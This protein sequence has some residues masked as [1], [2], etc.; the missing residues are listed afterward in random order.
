VASQ[1]LFGRVVAKS[2]LVMAGVVALSFGL[3]GVASAAAIT[4]TSIS[5]TPSIPDVLTAN[6]TGGPATSYQW[7]DCTGSV[8]ATVVGAGSWTPQAGCSAIGAATASTYALQSTDYGF[9]VTVAASESG[10]PTTGVAASV[11]VTEPAPAATGSPSFA[12]SSADVFAGTTATVSGTGFVSP[13]YNL[14]STTYQ[15]YDCTAQV[16]ADSVGVAAPGGCAAIGG[17]T[18]SSYQFAVNDVGKFVAFSETQTNGAGFATVFSTST[19]SAIVGATPVNTVSPTIGSQTAFTVTVTSHGTWTGH[20]APSSYTVTWYRC[21]ATEV[22]GST[23]P[24]ACTAIAGSATTTPTGLVTYT[25]VAADQNQYVLAGVSANNGIASANTAY[26]A[27]SAQISGVAPAVATPPA[28]TGT[29]QVGQTLSVSSG[30]WTGLPQPLNFNYQWYACVTDPAFSGGGNATGA[31]PAGLTGH[32]CASI[33]GATANTFI[34][35][36]TQATQFMV[37]EVSTNN[38][39]GSFYHF[40]ASTAAV[41]GPTLPTALSA[42]ISGTAPN[43]TFT[44]TFPV[45]GGSPTPVLTYHWFDCT[46]PVAASAG[47]PQTSTQAATALASCSAAHNV[48]TQTTYSVLA[49]DVTSA[50]GGGLVAEVVATNTAGSGYAWSATTALANAAPSGGVV[51]ESGS[52]AVSTPVTSTATWTAMPAPTITYQWYD[53]PGASFNGSCVAIA[54]ATGSTYTATTLAEVNTFGNK[55]D[56][57]VV[58]ATANNGVG[59]NGPIDATGVLL[60]TQAPSDVAPPTVPLTASTASALVP[61]VGTWQGA[62]T[63]TFT[64]QWYECTSPVA[65]AGSSAPA[66]CSAIA[67]AINVTYTPSGS[68]VGDYF[69]VA[70]TGSNGVLTGG[71]GSTALTVFSAST[72]SPLVSSLSISSLTITGTAAVGGTLTANPTVTATGTY[73][74][75]Y[76]WYSCTAAVVEG[77]SVPGTCAPIAG[78]TTATFSPTATQV[79]KYITVAVTVANLSGSATEVAA[80][81]ALV[82]TSAPGAPTSVVATAGLG[83]VSLTWV[84]PTTG[85]AVVTYTAT[86][87]TGG[88]TCTVSTTSCTVVGPLYGTLYSFT[89]TATNAAGTGPAS[90]ASNS[91]MPSE[92]AP[93]APTAVAGTAGNQSVLV[94]WTAS[95]NNGAI[96]TLYTVTTSPGG[97]SCTATTTSCTVSGLTNGTPYTFTVTAKNAVGTGAASAASAAVTPAAAPSAPALTGASTSGKGALKVS[98]TA[99]TS[100]G[101][102]VTGYVVTASGSGGSKTCSTAALSCTV[103]GLNPGSTYTVS[104]VAQS[105]VGNS[106]VSSSRSAKVASSPNAPKVLRHSATAT[107]ITLVLAKPTNN[108]GAAVTTYQYYVSGFG[109]RTA[110]S[111]SGATLVIRGLKAGRVYSVAVRAVN[112]AGPGSHGPFMQIRTL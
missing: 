11:L 91:V 10:T 56:Y 103:S 102:A 67:G 15:W 27:T 64:F 33:G 81:T 53:C 69:L 57:V 82:T 107:T 9:N 92:A 45:T 52:G 75:T 62:P 105:A 66:G 26:S 39:V 55:I 112:A 104:V 17:A 40:T 44:G 12:V 32:G 23:L 54:G 97:L 47:T 101:S 46:S 59:V 108:G 83:S 63:P 51:T 7:Y 60:T 42:S 49:S 95:V 34:L 3:A 74:T 65:S 96:V 13:V 29:L 38:G 88:F 70:V 100:N 58:A 94:S 98:W 21:G 106:T 18:A 24:G 48:S 90:A 89:V 4:A 68:Y 36:I 1:S 71:G 16:L 19:S 6:V 5:G 20:P 50:A 85:L 99:A 79:G 37:A 77:T 78:A 73:T 87:S 93:A 80:S 30:T 76:Q 110:S 2:G 8:A 61:S 31:L 111:R 43:G 41:T 25:F 22:A 84:A 28:V 109:W 72:Q 35:S 86:S 14:T